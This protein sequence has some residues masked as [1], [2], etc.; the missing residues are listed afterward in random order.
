MSALSGALL[1]Y[2]LVAGVLTLCVAAVALAIFRRTIERH[3]GGMAGPTPPGA[4]EPDARP[5]R[6][7]KVPLAIQ[8]ESSALPGGSAGPDDR[9]VRRLALAHAMAGLAFAIVAAVLLL[10]LSGMKIAPIRTAVVTRAYAWPV[11]PVLGLL[12]GPDRRAQGQILLYYFGGLLVLCVAASLVADPFTVAGIR[13]PGFL[14][15]AFLWTVRAAPSLFLLLFLNRAV[16]AIG[17]VAFPFF[18]VALAGTYVSL[19]ILANES[20]LRAAGVFAQHSGIGGHATFWGVAS[21]GLLAGSWP[22]WRAAVFLSDRYAAKRFSNLTLIASTIWL[23]ASLLLA[24]SLAAETGAVGVAAALLP[25]VAWKITLNAGLRPLAEAAR[26]RPA[27]HLLLLRV[28]G[29]GSRSQRLLD[30]LGARWRVLGSI[31]LIAAP[32]LAARTVEPATFL[33]FVR[34]RLGRLFIYTSSDLDQR[35]ATIDRKP[36]PDGRFRINQLFCSGEIWK[37]AVTRLMGG[38]S[39]VVMD[40]RGFG[41]EHRGCAF[42]LQTLLDSVPLT[43]LVLLIDNSTNQDFLRSLLT[44]HW[45]H[46]HAD[47]PNLAL[48]PAELRLLDASGGDAQAV[49]RLLATAATLP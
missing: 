43:R 39:L 14:V 36:D 40:L 46:L 47:S 28:F 10:L 7:P 26:A 34:G 4:S 37:L 9:I 49:R 2:M 38:A 12:V 22:A 13:V 23:L 32:D 15:P 35:F 1:F 5:R 24:S 45:R 42:E 6:A 41:P 21:I 18:A 29:F 3:M 33:E 11:V 8:V 16:R 20:V 31:D 44:E 25:F 27:A 48:E 17:P 19:E 30:V